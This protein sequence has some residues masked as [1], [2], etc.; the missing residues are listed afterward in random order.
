MSGGL[1][2]LLKLVEQFSEVAIYTRSKKRVFV[3]AQTPM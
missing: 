2:N 3:H 1:T